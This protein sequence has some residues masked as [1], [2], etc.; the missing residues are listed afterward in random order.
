MP[1]AIHRF[2]GEIHRM[3]KVQIGNADRG[4]ADSLSDIDETWIVQQIHRR[5]TDGQVVCVRVFVHVGCINVVLST[6]AC[7]CSGGGG[8]LPNNAEREVFLCWGRLGLDRAD[9]T[10][11]AVVAFLRQLRRC[12]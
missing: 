6:P 8:R 1:T 9:F 4:F 7:P 3:I 10:V 5:R 12:L 2:I 11:D